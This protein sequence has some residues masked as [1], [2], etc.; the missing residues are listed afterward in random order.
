M[1]VKSRRRYKV[2][3]FLTALA[4]ICL[5]VLLADRERKVPVP[6]K[7][8]AASPERSVVVI[9]RSDDPELPDPAPPDAVLSY[10]QVDAIVKRA[11]S[12]DRSERRLDRVIEP[13]DWVVVKPNI[14]TCTPIRDN[15]LGMGN[16][17]KRHKGQVTDLRVVKSVV[18]YLVHMER[19]PRRITI[20]EGGAEWRNLN[21][22]L[23]NPSQTE[24]GWTV[25]WPEF[26]GLSYVDIVDEYDGV[27]G[28]KVDIVDLNYD[29][30]LDA[31]GV[32]RGNGPPIPVPDP[33][34]TG[35]TWLQR[36]EGYY[37][38]K[39]LLECDKLIN[40]PVMKTHDIPGVTLIFKNYVGTFMQRAYG[41]TDNFKMLLHRYAGDENVPEGFIDLFSYRPT[42]YAIVECFWGTE[43]NGPQ[44][45]D[46]VKLNLVVAGGDPVATEAVAAA[47]MGFNPRDLDYLYW[48]E[49]KGFGTFDMDRI[50]V[51]GRSIEEVRYSFKK[52]KGPGGKGPGFVGRPNRVWL[53]NGPY[54]GNDLDVDYIGEHGISPE[55]GSVS[56]GKE[57]MR[58]ESGEDYIDLSQV[59]GAEPTVTAYAFT[60]I[61][62]DSDLNAQMWTG[63]DDGIKVWLNDEV[64]LE[65]ER[66][67]GKSLT[68]NK[69]PVHLRKGINRLLVKVRNLYGGYGFSLGIF[70]EDGDTP[71]GLRY[72]LGHQVQVKETTPAPSGFA[73]HRSYPNPFNR[74]TTIPFKVPEESLV[75]LEVYE[76]SG[77]RIRTLVNAR[78]GAGEHRIVWDGRDDEGREVSSGV[79]VVRMEAGGFS[80]ASKI[81][82]L[83]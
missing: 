19:P 72:L 17:G 54:E 9:V 71:W 26:G 31:D 22:P 47:V 44:W 12:L 73:L 62:V 11:I 16:D 56:G 75:R 55:E 24:D 28:V 51:V 25:H 8:G 67:G 69:V 23:R 6:P 20:A 59:L 43:G 68:R 45:G 32:V 35:I 41:Q 58:Y 77:R 60:Y 30:W 40:L 65:K 34:H 49:A 3:L 33:N 64:V 66:A 82:L 52:S 79:Y 13:G 2:A 21:D 10:D 37:V 53:L 39:T 81:T 36:P 42:D 15:Y 61:Y 29:D 1:S 14:V 70:E 50:E 78:M 57:W 27:N 80:E 63:A 46:D 76:I 48:A 5:D 7:V 18:D 83:R 38:S 74:W 4:L